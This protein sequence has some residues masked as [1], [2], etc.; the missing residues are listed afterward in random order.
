MR[1]AGYRFAMCASIALLSYVAYP[2]L[3]YSTIMMILR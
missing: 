1:V 2:G 3:T